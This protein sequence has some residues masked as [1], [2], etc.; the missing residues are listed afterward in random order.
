MRCVRRGLMMAVR[1]N[2]E[3]AR[4][5]VGPSFFFSHK[6]KLRLNMLVAVV[7][8][9]P[10]GCGRSVPSGSPPDAVGDERVGSG[11]SQAA[12]TDDSFRVSFSKWK[13]TNVAWDATGSL[14]G[15]CST[16]FRN[17]PAPDLVVQEWIGEAPSLDGKFVLVEFWATWCLPCQR[18]ILGLNEISKA[19]ADDL[20]LIGISDES[21]EQVRSMS[22]PAIEYYSGVDTQGRTQSAIGVKLLP[23]ALFIDPSGKVC[24]QGSPISLADPLTHRLIR[25]RI[26]RYRDE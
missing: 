24:W 1:R 12:A 3:L 21:V 18:S 11:A 2:K 5:G 13:G 4:L 9:L 15:F 20:V 19:F 10:L 16:D 14:E 22:K 6:G 8:V 26:Q 7:L 17:Q 23:H 25:D